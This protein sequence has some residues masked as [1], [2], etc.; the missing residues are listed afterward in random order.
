[1]SP[2]SICSYK[3]LPVKST[4]R[5]AAT[6]GRP[7][8]VRSGLLACLFLLGVFSPQLAAVIEAIRRRPNLTEGIG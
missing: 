8:M 7:I 5:V 3:T 1:M 6:M 4:N 2:S